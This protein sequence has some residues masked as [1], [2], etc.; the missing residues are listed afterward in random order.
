MFKTKIVADDEFISEVQ[1]ELIQ[2]KI[3]EMVGD[4]KTDGGLAIVPG[5][6]GK[7]TYIRQWAT[8]EHAQEFIDFLDA[9][10]DVVGP[11]DS[12]TIVEEE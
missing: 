7:T 12:V 5:A 3:D 6:D 9:N 8:S 2:S 1:S 11:R 4:S 10:I